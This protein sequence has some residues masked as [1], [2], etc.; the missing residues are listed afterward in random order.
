MCVCVCVCVQI[1]AVHSLSHP[2]N[3]Q[4]RAEKIDKEHKE[5]IDEDKA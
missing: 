4:M 5:N 1:D 3:A 2:P